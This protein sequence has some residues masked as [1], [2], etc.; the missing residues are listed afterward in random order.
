MKI[1]LGAFEKRPGWV[2]MDR[3]PR[4]DY[5]HDFRFPLPFMDNSIDGI[6]SSHLLE[7]IP[8]NGIIQLLRECFR[9]LKPGYLFEAAVPNAKLYIDRYYMDDPPE[10]P[11]TDLYPPAFHY[12]SKIDFINYFAYLDGHHQ[13]LF[14][15]KNLPLIVASVGFRLVE[16]RPFKEGLDMKA[17]D[18]ETIY[19]EAYK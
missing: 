18:H 4:S 16:L 8:H 11:D 10:I 3:D 17:R 14:D 2:T 6:Y 5:P 13:F 19:V 1:E 9:V 15:E 7:H 12:Y